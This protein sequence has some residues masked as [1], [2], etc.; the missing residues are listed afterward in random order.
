M[1]GRATHGGLSRHLSPF[2][3]LSA[4]THRRPD[5]FTHN[6]TTYQDRRLGMQYRA[7]VYLDGQWWME[8]T[9]GLDYVTDH[10]AAAVRA[11]APARENR[12]F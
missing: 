11:P 3:V 6:L 9:G 1:P 2:T 4:C 7:T 10:L 5:V 8:W 12:D